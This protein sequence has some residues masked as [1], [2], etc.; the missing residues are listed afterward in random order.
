MTVVSEKFSKV[1]PT[2]LGGVEAE[3]VAS[4]DAQ[5]ER[6]TG[7]VELPAVVVEE[8][9]PQLVAG[10]LG[11]KFGEIGDEALMSPFL[12]FLCFRGGL[13]ADHLH[14]LGLFTPGL[15][16]CPGEGVPR[17]DVPSR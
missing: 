2:S 13:S 11:W 15:L 17:E 16:S 9:G 6:P 7:H 3:E 10:H 1:Q 14:P 5:E 4:L 8:Q 12:D